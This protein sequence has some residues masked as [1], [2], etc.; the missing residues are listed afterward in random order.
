MGNFF[1]NSLKPPFLQDRI[2]RSMQHFETEHGKPNKEN[3]QE[4]E[5]NSADRL[6]EI[7]QEAGDSQSVEMGVE[8]LN[9][10]NQ[11]EEA[12][13]QDNDSFEILNQT[14]PESKSESKCLRRSNKNKKVAEDVSGNLSLEILN[15]TPLESKKKCQFR[16]G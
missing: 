14:P 10:I 2:R 9:H 4:E 11:E 6:N 13:H 15:Q 16:K 12:D 1:M 8:G 7:N 3:D 5:T